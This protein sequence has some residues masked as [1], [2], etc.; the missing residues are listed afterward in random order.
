MAEPNQLF[1]L[2]SNADHILKSTINQ[3]WISW[4][5]EALGQTKEIKIE[6]H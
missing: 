5:L 4:C 3:Y 2:P 6:L 1:H